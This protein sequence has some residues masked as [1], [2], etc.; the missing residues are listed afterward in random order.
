L[1]CDKYYNRSKL[2]PILLEC[3]HKICSECFK[4]LSTKSNAK[5]PFDS[6]KLTA[7]GESKQIQRQKEL[8]TNKQSVN[9]GCEIKKKHDSYN[10]TDE[11]S[12]K[13]TSTTLNRKYDPDDLRV[14][15]T[16]CF[17]Y[18]NKRN[19]IINKEVKKKAKLNT[20]P[21]SNP[22][23]SPPQVQHE[24]VVKNPEVQT[25]IEEKELVNEFNEKYLFYLF[26]YHFVLNF[27]Y[28]AEENNPISYHIKSIFRILLL[29][30]FFIM[31]VYYK[32]VLRV[33]I[34]LCI[35]NLY[36]RALHQ[37]N[38]KEALSETIGIW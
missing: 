4:E 36:Y 29:A 22:K 24:E 2:T 34:F 5:C 12:I 3:N 9:N 1:K 17:S 32:S 38:M 26:V 6:Q 8:N 27:I 7:K 10:I 23:P 37:E 25:S 28:T 30:M 19:L 16:V 14:Y 11:T 21:K 31:T 20:K 18:V 33:F 15:R 35:I 13:E